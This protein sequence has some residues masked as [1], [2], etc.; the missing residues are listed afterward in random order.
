M[1]PTRAQAAPALLR[2]A[3]ASA[4]YRRGARPSRLKQQ[5][6]AVLAGAAT[7]RLAAAARLPARWP[8]SLPVVPQVVS[9]RP[10][11]LDSTVRAVSGTAVFPTIARDTKAALPR[12]PAHPKGHAQQ[13][14]H[15]QQQQLVQ[16]HLLQRQQQ[17][18]QQFVQQQQLLVQQQRAAKAPARAAPDYVPGYASPKLIA[19]PPHRP[20]AA[21]DIVTPPRQR[22][23][24]VAAIAT[25]GGTAEDRIAASSSMALEAAEKQILHERL[26]QQEKDKKKAQWEDGEF[27]PSCA[28]SPAPGR[29]LPP[30]HRPTPSHPR[31]SSSQSFAESSSTRSSRSHAS[32]STLA[33][34]RR[35]CLVRLDA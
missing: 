14:P 16:Q 31:V 23:V 20:R 28:L 3:L 18:Q 10:G 29:H 32:N 9:H 33:P 13:P 12:P 8:A 5:Q 6:L 26:V 34:L 11:G 22:G 21:P 4:R 2:A 17:Q 15:L 27:T 25:G 7:T 30:P 19:S 1:P 35:L 24:S